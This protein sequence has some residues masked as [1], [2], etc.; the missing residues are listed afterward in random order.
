VYIERFLGLNDVVVWNRI[1][2]RQSESLYATISYDQL[3]G[4]AMGIVLCN[5]SADQQRRQAQE[6]FRCI[7]DPFPFLGMGSGRLAVSVLW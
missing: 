6:I 4:N 7:L 5:M 2:S 3:N 1:L